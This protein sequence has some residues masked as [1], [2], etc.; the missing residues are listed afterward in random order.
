MKINKR[1]ENKIKEQVL[2]YYN[3]LKNNNLCIKLIG[4]KDD[5]KFD[6]NVTNPR[7]ESSDLTPI[8]IS[9][10]L[11]YTLKSINEE[12]LCFKHNI[13][14]LV[15]KEFENLNFQIV[16]IKDEEIKGTCIYV[17]VKDIEFKIPN[18]KLEHTITRFIQFELKVIAK[19]TEI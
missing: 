3:P 5:F 19:N 2:E 7:I 12:I 4:L 17:N 1:I 11:K 10:D 6:V 18:Y 13:E 16:N 9:R 15:A 14:P 8:S